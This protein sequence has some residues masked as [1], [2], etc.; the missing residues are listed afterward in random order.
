ML[1]VICIFFSLVGCM[2]VGSSSARAQAPREASAAASA[3]VPADSLLD[4]L[5]GTWRMVGQVHGQ[6]VRYALAVDR[7]LHGQYV[8]LHMTD[9][10]QPSRYEARVFVGADTVAGRVLVHWLDN[11]GAAFS[12]PA[13]S[14]SV[15]GDTLRFYIPYSTGPFRDTFI[16]DPATDAWIFR[17]ESG[18][19]SGAWRPFADYDVRRTGSSGSIPP[20]R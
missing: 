5:V 9:V 19:G 2:S 17:L 1:R 10:N 20:A 14:G 12:V 16:Y 3:P 15:A 11:F 7:V 6:P 8:E 18:D 13:G 4:H